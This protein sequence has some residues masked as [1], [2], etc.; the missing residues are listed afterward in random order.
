MAALENIIMGLFGRSKQNDAMI[1][2]MRLLLDNF[3]FADLQAFCVDILGESPAIDKEHL[4]KI[5]VL[6]F[7]WDKYHKGKVQFSQLKEFAIKRNLVAENFF[8]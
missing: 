7:V 4:S 6:D 5:E 8:E 2:Q 1:E 3:Q